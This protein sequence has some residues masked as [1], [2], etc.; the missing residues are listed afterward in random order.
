MLTGSK[1]V[2]KQMDT[3]QY[4]INNNHEVMIFNSEED[5][6]EYFKFFNYTSDYLNNL[7]LISYKDYLK[8][9]KLPDIDEDMEKLEE[10]L[11]KSVKNILEEN[12]TKLEESIPFYFAI[13]I[14]DKA[15]IDE[16]LFYNQNDAGNDIGDEVYELVYDIVEKIMVPFTNDSVEYFQDR[17][18]FL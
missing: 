16:I 10:K 4:V 6:V 13:N 3:N 14:Y 12:K 5:C 1:V 18:L 2:A 11:I 8:E 15:K 7:K 17:N 9:N